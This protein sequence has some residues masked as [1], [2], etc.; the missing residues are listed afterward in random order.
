[1]DTQLR[2]IL[3]RSGSAGLCGDEGVSTDPSEDTVWLPWLWGKVPAMGDE[4]AGM[5]DCTVKS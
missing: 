4:V 1:M 3:S 5:I 2:A